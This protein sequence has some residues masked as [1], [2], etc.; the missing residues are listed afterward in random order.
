MKSA[1]LLSLAAAAA[2]DES[3]LGI[4][5]F[6]RHG[7]RT[8]KSWPPTALTPLGADQVYASGTYFRDRYVSANATSRIA[9]LSSDLAVL[10]QISITA[11]VDN[12]LQ[13]SANVF[14]QGLYPPA[15][16]AAQQTLA[17]GT[18]TEAPL[19]GYQYIPVNIV[20]SAASASGSE[21]SGWLQGSSGCN[22]AIVSSNQYFSSAEYLETLNSTAEFYQSVLPVVNTTFTSAQD[23]FKNAYTV[24]DYI[25]VSTIHNSSIPSSDLLTNETLFQLQTRADQHEWGLAYNESEPVRAIAGAVLAGEILQGLNPTVLAAPAKKSASRLVFQFGAY[26][27]FMAFFGLAN[28]QAVSTD[29]MGVVD[30]ASSIVFE[31]VTNSTV[32]D[33]PLDL[34]EISVRFRFAN[35]SAGLDGGLHEFP[36]F[37]QSVTPLPWTTFESEMKRFSIGDTVSWCNACGNTTG[38]CSPTNLGTANATSASTDSD[39]SSSGISRPV[40][41]VI[42]ALVTLAVVLGV[43]SLILLVG[44]LRVVKKGVAAAG[45]AASSA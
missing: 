27:T 44:G 26:G 36:L 5:V 41:G 19:G 10:S 11:P 40:A 3:V 28:M 37:G 16:T 42:G 45:K 8:T 30:Y 17:N 7:D 18:V 43:E 25:H 24:W 2:A 15:G 31:L 13:N 22:N 6:H 21:D 32:T 4:Y 33:T 9:A 23:T 38:V 39:S 12:V 29:F 20:S 34:D 14:T 1:V 35:G